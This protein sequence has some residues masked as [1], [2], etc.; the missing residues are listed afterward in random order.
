LLVVTLEAIDI[1][2]PELTFFLSLFSSSEVEEGLGDTFLES[3][4]VETLLEEYLIVQ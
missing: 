2:E 1:L 3:S 4:V